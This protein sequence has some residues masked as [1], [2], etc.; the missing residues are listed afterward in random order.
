MLRLL[1]FAIFTVLLLAAT[2]V[3]AQPPQVLFDQINEAEL[4]HSKKCNVKS[5][6]LYDVECMVYWN[7]QTE[8]VWVVLFDD[9]LEITH[10]IA[11]G[12]DRIE[13]VLWQTDQEIKIN[14]GQRI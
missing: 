12:P 6:D 8:T 3:F 5:L 11:N 10:V 7:E 13:R 2:A 1:C 4:V 14:G 9:E